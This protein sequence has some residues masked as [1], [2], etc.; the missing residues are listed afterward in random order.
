MDFTFSE[1]Q[2]A[3]RRRVRRVLMSEVSP[4]WLREL[5]A[6]DAGPAA[7]AW[8]LLTGVGL[9][10]VSIA[11][12][13]GGRGGTDV[14]WVLLAQE[15]GYHALPGALLDT[16]WIGAALLADLPDGTLGA[17]WLPRIASGQARLAIGHPVQRLVADAQGA[18]LLLLNHQGELHALAPDQVRLALNPSVDGSRRLYRVD[19]QPGTDTRIAD[20]PTAR[21][22]WDRALDRGA[23]AVAAQCSGLAMRMLD[24][25]IDHSAQR[26]QF[27]KPI[28]SFQAVKHALADVSVQI[29]FAK[30]VMVQAAYALQQRDALAALY[31]S[32]AR[33][34]AGDA[35]RLAARH[36][37]QVHGASGYAWDGDLQIF[38]KRAWALDAA[39]GTRA[40]HKARVAKLVLREGAAIGARDTFAGC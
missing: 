21:T 31:V 27:G 39:W 25:A 20:A 24:L 3:E 28:G 1:A 2:L 4:E 33:L 17:Q 13:H 19:W 14:D 30:P 18:D 35:V 11:A 10:A 16:A 26:R 12:A 32:H 9:T 15:L 34:A 7:G 36:G 8:P 37:L 5:W 29:D 6:S 23:L 40:L 38:T 22:L